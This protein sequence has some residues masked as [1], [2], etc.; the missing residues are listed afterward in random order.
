MH[1]RVDTYEPPRAE[2]KTYKHVGV[3]LG[4]YPLDWNIKPT[5]GPLVYTLNLGPFALSFIF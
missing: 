5:W 4:F 2:P 1:N 3:M